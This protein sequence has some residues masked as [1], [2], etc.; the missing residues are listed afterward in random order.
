MCKT[1]DRAAMRRRWKHSCVAIKLEYLRHD[2]RPMMLASGVVLMLPHNL[3][4]EAQQ[5][6]PSSSCDEWS[7]MRPTILFFCIRVSYTAQ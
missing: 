6:P 7:K 1:L 5:C 4:Y 3:Q 2:V